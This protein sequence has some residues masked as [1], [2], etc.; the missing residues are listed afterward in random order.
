M[1]R[2]RGSSCVIRSAFGRRLIARAGGLAHL[3]LIS[4]CKAALICFS[5][6]AE[7]SS[8]SSALLILSDRDANGASE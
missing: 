4:C 1:M 7:I 5:T 3:F 2:Q 6:L 8:A